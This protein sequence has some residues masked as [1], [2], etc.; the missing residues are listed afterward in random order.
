MNEQK[1]TIRLFFNFNTKKIVKITNVLKWE[2]SIELI[3]YAENK[4]SGAPSDDNIINIHFEVNYMMLIVYL[5][6]EGLLS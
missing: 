1:C 2:G 6:R 4:I 3:D 5:K